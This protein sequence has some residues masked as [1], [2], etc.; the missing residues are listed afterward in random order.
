MSWFD[1]FRP[2]GRIRGRCP[3]CGSKNL[4][5]TIS[6]LYCNDCDWDILKR[7]CVSERNDNWYK[8]RIF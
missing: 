3:R 6:R 5:H 4:G 2:R 1:L 8:E 7:D